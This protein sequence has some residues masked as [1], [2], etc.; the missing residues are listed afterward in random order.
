[1]FDIIEGMIKQKKYNAWEV[2][3]GAVVVAPLGSIIELACNQTKGGDY[4]SDPT[5]YQFDS[6]REATDYFMARG[7]GEGLDNW[8][9]YSRLSNAGYT[10]NVEMVER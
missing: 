10:V 4:S 6:E 9:A 3:Q 2:A 1:M 8:L 5:R 7:H